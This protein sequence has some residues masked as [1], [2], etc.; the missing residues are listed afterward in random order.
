MTDTSRL[1]LLSKCSLRL[2]LRGLVMTLREDQYTLDASREGS[3]RRVRR[4]IWVIA[5]Q[6]PMHSISGIG[7]GPFSHS[8]ILK[9]VFEKIRSLNPMNNI[10]SFVGAKEK[11]S[12]LVTRMAYITG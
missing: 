3:W 2:P 12:F 4:G 7:L 8:G 11:Y 10:M 1:R 6:G 5:F 9:T